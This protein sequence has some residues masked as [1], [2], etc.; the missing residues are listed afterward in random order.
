MPIVEFLEAAH[1]SVS[2]TEGSFD[3]LKVLATHPV[4]SRSELLRVKIPA[5]PRQSSVRFV[6]PSFANLARQSILEVEQ[7]LRSTKIRFRPVLLRFES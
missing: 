4:A 6:D 3:A 2:R 7:S 5:Y 1:R